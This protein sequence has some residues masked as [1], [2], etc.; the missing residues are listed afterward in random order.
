[1]MA[2][3]PAPSRALVEWWQPVHGSDWCLVGLP[4]G[5]QLWFNSRTNSSEWQRPVETTGRRLCPRQERR[6]KPLPPPGGAAAG[7][8]VA[9]APV[10]A[11][12]SP[13]AGVSREECEAE[14]E[15]ML[16]DCGVSRGAPWR[17]VL[18]L[19]LCDARY[20]ALETLN[21]RRTA[22]EKWSRR[23]SPPAQRPAPQRQGGEGGGY[24]ALL[25][26]HATLKTTFRDF[27]R[28]HLAD[29]R[30]K[31]VP[32]QQRRRDLFEEWVEGLKRKQRGEAGEPEDPGAKRRRVEA[33]RSEAQ[34]AAQKRAEAR[35]EAAAVF[36]A[37]QEA[38]ATAG[39]AAALRDLLQ[40]PGEGGFDEVA[41]RNPALAEAAEGLPLGVC[42]ELLEAHRRSTAAS[43][44]V[45]SFREVIAGAPTVHFTTPWV[46]ARGALGLKG[47][48]QEEQ[49][50][51]WCAQR[52]AQCVDAF[53]RHLD[54]LQLQA[55]LFG[56]TEEEAA[57][58]LRGHSSY[59]AL[60]CAPEL[61]AQ[62]LRPYRTHPPRASGK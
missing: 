58:V 36:S 51:T 39:L 8:E 43:N 50:K 55:P 49:Y 38:R 10:D 56:K 31:S 29:P 12:P 15:R 19:I 45:A 44:A 5:A 47:D 57:L 6:E 54:E 3:G 40:G 28:R 20:L 1:M 22:Y 46:E 30:F 17:S 23:R 25:E 18:P 53:R 60:D 52:R 42:E 32:S 7:G 61:R 11:V 59:R 62:I 9:R 33:A 35:A 41:R 2:A 27:Q 48:G 16:S 34:A 37:A 14:F 26:Q 21:D 4:G 13:W 24:A